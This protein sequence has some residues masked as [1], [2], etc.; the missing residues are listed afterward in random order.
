MYNIL[1]INEN[2]NSVFLSFFRCWKLWQD[3]DPGKLFKLSF[4][5][6]V[7]V[8]LISIPD[9]LPLKIIAPYSL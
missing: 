9:A 5:L 3:F 2:N 8:F 4:C 1:Y 7:F 6:H